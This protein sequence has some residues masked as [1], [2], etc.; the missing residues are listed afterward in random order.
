[1]KNKLTI[2]KRLRQR[3]LPLMFLIITLLMS[4]LLLMRIDGVQKH[5]LD[6]ATEGARNIFRMIVLTRQWNSNHGGVY[7][8][9]DEKTPVNEYL[10]HPRKVIE[11][12]EKEKLTLLNPAYMTRQ[13]AELAQNDPDTHLRLHITSLKPIRPQNAADAWEV[14][15]L[16]R[17]ETGEQ[18]ISSVEIENGQRYLRYMS[19][20]MVKE[21]C[22]LCHEK[23]GYK[24][25][26]VRGGISVSLQMESI[27]KSVH[28]EIVASAI[29]YAVSYGLL[30]MITW[31][32]I[33]LLARRWRALNDNIE[34]LETTRNELV[35][36]EKMA[37][38]GRLVSGFAHEINT[39]VG[40]AVGAI[41]H[42]DETIA[43]LKTLLA[44]EEVT[45]QELNQQLD[46]LSEGHYLAL[47]NLRRAADLVQRFKRTSIDRDS[48][49]KREY[50]PAELIQDVLT[51]LH[52]QL[53][54]TEISIDVTCSE[55]LKLYG[56]PGLLEQVL[57]NLITNSISHGFDNGNRAG[58]I[59]INVS[60]SSANR[61]IVDYQDDGVGMNEDVK[62]Q[63]FEPFFTTS[64]E[65]GGSGLGLYVIYNIVTQQMAGTIQMTSV[66]NAGVRFHIECPI[67]A[68]PY[69]TL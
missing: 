7:V 29:S 38:L 10:E 68:I 31:G 45:E 23:Q 44:K 60:Q 63:A 21:S 25:G 9:V 58:K 62:Q 15:A 37:S 69:N 49:Q 1:M 57:T 13:I 19:P 27:D 40:V 20:L 8:F 48:Q 41:S 65:K 26:D 51:T 28:H 12:T 32:L 46:Y 55:K 22:L 5:N 3:V 39:P 42:G 53:K 52:N 33:E 16:K 43:T 61:L 50:Q 64:R 18:E 34:M 6:V 54:R 66:S 24:L 2:D 30:I 17:F 11:T 35:E 47:A 14:E 36:N 56:T 67:E 4:M 59:S